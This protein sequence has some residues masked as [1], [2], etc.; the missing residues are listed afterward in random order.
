MSLNKILQY[1]YFNIHM[2]LLRYLIPH[3]QESLNKKMVFLGGP[4]QVG[5]TT[6]SLQFLKSPSIE[7]PAYLNWDRNT[8]RIQILKDQ[9]PLQENKILVL[10]ELHK[11]SKWRN[12]IKGLF[13]KYHTKNQ[14]IITG[15]ARLDYFRKGGD[16]LLG[17]YRYFRLHPFSVMEMNKNPNKNDLDI[18][19][20]F[21]GFPEPLF[22]QNEKEHRIWQN[23]RMI[24]V[25]SEDIRDL[26]NIKDISSMLLLAEMLPARVGSPLSLKSIS[27]DLQVS[28]PTVDRWIEI[29]STLYYCYTIAPFGSPKIRAV[30]KLKKL[31]LWDWSQVEEYGF[32]FENLVASHLLKYCHFIT[33]TEGYPMEIRYLRDTDGREIDF[34]VL[35]NKKPLFAVECKTGEKALSPHISYF[36]ARTEI[37]EFFQVHMGTKDFG[38]NKTGRVLP[39]VKFC[40]EMGMI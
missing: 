11:Y 4:R 25:A 22:S 23:D 26:E 5:K 16:S 19:L 2:K 34:V 10:D 6:L 18:L 28:Q 36:Q 38:S 8:D 30:R 40:K 12:L 1:E 21:G 29:L 14:F 39:F 9:F 33:D 31:Y 35:K 20:K 17:R 27:E 7:N 32:R 13:D 3:M 15:S 24:K 37:P